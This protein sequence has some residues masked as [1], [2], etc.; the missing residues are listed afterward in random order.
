MPLTSGTRLGHY[1]V[2]API[3][4]GGMGEVYRA[5]ETK[6]NRDGAIKILEAMLSERIAQRPVPLE[7]ATPIVEQLID[8]LEYAHEKNVVHRDLKP[9][10]IKITPEG[11]RKSVV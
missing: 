10:N 11:D 3:G 7:E 8:A 9:A 4:S 5:R 2:L 6:L 1:E